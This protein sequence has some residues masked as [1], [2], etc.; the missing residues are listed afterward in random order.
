M[1]LYFAFLKLGPLKAVYHGLSM[2][3]GFCIIFCIVLCISEAATRAAGNGGSL[4]KS[5]SRD[6]IFTGVFLI[7][8]L[9]FLFSPRPDGFSFGDNIG[10]IIDD[11]RLTDYGW[12]V[13]TASF[14]R[15]IVT[16]IL[17][18]VGCRTYHNLVLRSEK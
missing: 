9:V 16:A 15:S 8:S 1:G 10:E 18:F 6:A 14:W 4:R 13:Q 11:G 5:L 17:F 12:K 2:A 7:C 3:F